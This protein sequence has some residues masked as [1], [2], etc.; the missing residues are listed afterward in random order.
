[1]ATDDDRHS[2]VILTGVMLDHIF[3]GVYD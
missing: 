2:V 1:L 3:R